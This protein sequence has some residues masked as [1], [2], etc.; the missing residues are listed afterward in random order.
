M[1]YVLTADVPGILEHDDTVSSHFMVPMG[2]LRSESEGS[3]LQ[4][5]NE[6]V[7]APG[8]HIEP[9]YH[10]SL[11]FYYVLSGRATMRVGDQV[12]EVAPGDLIYTPKNVPHS[13]FAHNSGVRCLAFATAFMPEGAPGYTPVVFDNWPPSL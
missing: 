6:F 4:F 13:I 5:I 1:E 3:Y 2:A 8:R 10:D 12:S 9:H 11:E 7:V